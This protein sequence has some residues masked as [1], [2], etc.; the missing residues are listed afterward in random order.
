MDNEE[1]HMGYII[2]ILK[3]LKKAKFWIK[4]EKCIFYINK[5]EYLKFIIIS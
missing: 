2:I 5:I 1:E 3:I 4:L